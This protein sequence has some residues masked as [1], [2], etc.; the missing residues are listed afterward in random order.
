MRPVPARPAREPILNLPPIVTAAILLL[1][2]VH[3]ARILFLDPEADLEL[4]IDFAVVP[5]RWT[6]AL[7]PDHLPAILDTIRQDPSGMDP[8]ARLALADYVLGHGGIRP[9]TAL[10]YAL[11][12]GSWAHVLMNSIWL[13][14][15]GTPVARRCGAA[16][17]VV[18]AVATAVAGAV[19]H[20][21]LRPYDVTPMV[22]ASAAVSGLMASAAWFM[23]APP[24]WT[25][26]SP[27]APLHERPRETLAGLV[28][29]RRIMLFLLVWF[30]A[31]LLFAVL[32]APLG[33]TDASIAWQAHVGGFAAGLLLFPALD[34]VGGDPLAGTLESTADSPDH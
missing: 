12:H 28:R 10:T 18:L 32:A 25:V 6:A 23:F 8:E 5:V 19:L 1:V 20:A 27:P 33:I 14:A 17:F 11:L 4:L 26:L 13:A 30:A 2:A 34:P 24:R 9:W 15:F 31:N 3:G 21:L 22:G 16:R 7:M 29:N